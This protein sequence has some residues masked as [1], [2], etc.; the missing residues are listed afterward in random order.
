MWQ[1]HLDTVQ[2]RG[3]ST[4]TV[5]TTHFSDWSWAEA[6]R[7]TSARADVKVGQSVKFTLL[8]CLG[9]G[10][11]LL[12]PLVPTCAPYTLTPFTRNWAVNGA[13]GG[14][15]AEGTV[16]RDEGNTASGTYAAPARKPGINPVAVSVDLIPNERANNTVRLVAYARVTEDGPTCEEIVKGAYR[17]VYRLTTW[18][19]NSL[20]YTLPNKDPSS[21]ARDR[22]TGGF[23]QL[24]TTDEDLALGSGTYELRFEYDHKP[25]GSSVEVHRVRNDAG[26]YGSN[27]D[28]SATTFTSVSGL[29]YSSTLRDGTVTVNGFPM[30]TETFDGDVR[31]DFAR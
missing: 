22:L 1:A 3:A 21:D 11:D 23:L 24:N 13:A 2:D 29:K 5:S 19:G 6:Y 28:L 8:S 20:P 10:D 27:I 7:L 16:T 14:S 31:L 9:A 25:A 26:D 30:G 4:L 12:A 17:C 15:A 18:N